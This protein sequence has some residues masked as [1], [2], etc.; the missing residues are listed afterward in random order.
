MRIVIGNLPED[1]SEEK[2]REA[3]K[4]IAPPETITLVREGDP[5][6]PTAVIETEMSTAAAETVA[7]GYQWAHLPGQAAQGLGAVVDLVSR[8][9]GRTANPDGNSRTDPNHQ[10]REGKHGRKDKK[11]KDKNERKKGKQAASGSEAAKV[12]SDKFNKAGK[13]KREYYEKELAAP[14]RRTGRAAGMGQE[15]RRQG[16]RGLRGPRRGG[17]GRRDQG[18]HRARQPARVPRGSAARADR[19]REDAVVHAALHHPVSG[20]RRDRDIRPQLLQPGARESRHGLHRGKAGEALSR[21]GA[22]V[23]EQSSSKPASS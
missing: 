6:N 4:D 5:K 8:V 12:E 3:L 7:K 19:A 18:A 20:G 16:H 15:D 11:A 10:R 22:D 1:T 13:L 23:R 21:A 17:Q 14:A 9:A 2:L